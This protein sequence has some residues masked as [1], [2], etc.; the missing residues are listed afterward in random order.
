M[1]IKGREISLFRTGCLILYYGIAQF[2]P[3]T[4]KWFNIGGYL[5]YQLCRRIFRK[6]GANVNI[7]RRAWFG[8]GADI[9]IGEYSGIGINAHIPSDTIIG[10]YVMMGPNC[11]ILDSNHEF[12]DVDTPMCFQG[13]SQ[14][15]QTIIED[16]VWIGRDVCFTPGRYVKTGTIIAM[17][18]VMTKDFPEY[19]IVGGNPSELIRSRISKPNKQ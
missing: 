6:C 3:E 2:L 17:A 15:R 9:E 1:R 12:S 14:R 4:G 8:S 16:D 18:C 10:R 7:E 5:R 11:Y 13:H 19:S